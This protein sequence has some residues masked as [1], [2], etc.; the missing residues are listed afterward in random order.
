ML[1]RGAVAG[2]GDDS[3][4]RLG[5]GNIHRG[6]LE[7]AGRLE[8]VDQARVQG[9]RVER[10]TGLLTTKAAQRNFCGAVF[11]NPLRLYCC[12]Q[13][14]VNLKGVVARCDN[15]ELDGVGRSQ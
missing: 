12:I 1:D 6:T 11:G 13:A 8:V 10:A 14:L 15:R 9:A 5:N 7:V 2:T 4:L 3:R